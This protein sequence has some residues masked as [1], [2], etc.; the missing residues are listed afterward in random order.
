M[1]AHVVVK[2]TDQCP[3]IV[4]NFGDVGIKSDCSGICI[5]CIAVLVDLVIQY[6]D[7][8][9]ECRVA[10]ISVDRLL[11]GFVGFGIL[12]LGHVA[13]AEKIPA[14]RIRLIC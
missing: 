14:L 6:A 5:K 4:P 11:I 9:P 7:G 12:L 10:P 8:A 13:S 2:Q 3:K 1:D